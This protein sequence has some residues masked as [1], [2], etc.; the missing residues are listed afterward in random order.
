M[1]TI[2]LQLKDIPYELDIQQI[3]DHIRLILVEQYGVNPEFV[4]NDKDLIN[5]VRLS[6]MQNG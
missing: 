5:I 4:I 6:G 2:D 3:L 1:I